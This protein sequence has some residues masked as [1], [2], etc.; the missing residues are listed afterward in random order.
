MSNTESFSNDAPLPEN[1]P[2][3][4]REARVRD[5]EKIRQDFV[6]SRRI[7]PAKKVEQPS[8]KELHDDER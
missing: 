2:T 6:S 5:A 4:R 7:H 3:N 1:Y 8:V